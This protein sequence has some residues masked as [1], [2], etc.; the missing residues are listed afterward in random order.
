MPER[1]HLDQPLNRLRVDTQGV[2]GRRE[3]EHG[4]HH[5]VDPVHLLECLHIA[6]DRHSEAREPEGDE[7]YRRDCEDRRPG[8]VEAEHLH[9][10]EE[11]RCIDRAAQQREEDLTECHIQR[12]QRCR[13]HPLV[14]LGVLHLEKYVPG[15]VENRPVHRR[16]RKKCRRD[17]RRVR[18]GLTGRR[19]D[20]AD[21]GAK[22]DTQRQQIEHRLEKS[23]QHN[24][25][26]GTAGGEESPR[27]DR[28]RVASVKRTDAS[29]TGLWHRPKGGTGRGRA[30]LLSLRVTTT[31][32]RRQ[33]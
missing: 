23:T 31:W 9:H 17:E 3:K 5:E 26:V 1:E 13:E 14:Q 24:E 22:A 7:Q 2:E 19:R 33:P 29:G 18:H 32:V 20:R 12:P 25:P 6:G 27:D 8:A 16:H 4:Q 15:G 30:H 28:S 11:T 10:N 21:Q